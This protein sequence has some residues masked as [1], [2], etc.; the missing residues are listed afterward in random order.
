LPLG[1][2]TYGATVADALVVGTAERSE[3]RVFAADGALQRIVRWPDQERAVAGP[4]LSQWEGWLDEQLSGMPEAQRRDMRAAFDALPRPERFPAYADIVATDGP[5]FW[6]G[7][8][9]GQ[10]GLVGLPSEVP[11]PP[12]RRWW[13]FDLDGALVAQ[14]DTPAGFMPYG[15][16]GGR[17]W[18]VYKDAYLV[19]S[20]RAYALRRGS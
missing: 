6:V 8:Y 19:E 5:G 16:R 1:K 17:V 10:L 20:V 15:V 3:V 4:L 13:V 9:A 18:G 2:R 14:V 12:A 11:P 7:A